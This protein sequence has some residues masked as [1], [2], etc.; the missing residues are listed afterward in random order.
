[1]LLDVEKFVLTHDGVIHHTTVEKK[2]HL[3][4]VIFAVTKDGL[5]RTLV[6]VIFWLTFD[7]NDDLTVLLDVHCKSTSLEACIKLEGTSKDGGESNHHTVING[8]N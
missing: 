5:S 2:C 7:Y 8:K 3:G 1:M 6:L 4:E